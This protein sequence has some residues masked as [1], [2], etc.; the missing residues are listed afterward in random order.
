[1]V[2]RIKVNMFSK[3]KLC[4][5]VKKNVIRVKEKKNVIVMV[6]SIDWIWILNVLYV[7]F[8]YVYCLKLKVNI[9]L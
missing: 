3:I 2:F 9:C 6:I 5:N 1:M 8:C 4:I 7:E